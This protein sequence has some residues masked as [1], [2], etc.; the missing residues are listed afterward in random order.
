[1]NHARLWSD[2]EAHSM[3]G[4][5]RLMDPP[6]RF[7]VLDPDARLLWSGIGGSMGAANAL[8]QAL[9][10]ARQRLDFIPLVGPEP[11]PRSLRY[12]DQ[13]VFASRSGRTL[14]TWALISHLRSKP[15][16]GRWKNPPFVLTQDDGNP[17]ARMARAEAWHLLQLPSNVGGRY[18]AF[19]PIG[20]LPLT[21]MGSDIASYLRGARRVVQETQDGHGPW[22]SRVWMAVDQLLEG[23]HRNIKTWVLMPYCNQLR[24]LGAWWVQ[25]VAESL[26]KIAKDGA[27][28]GL[29]PIQAL[30][31]Q[32]QHSQLQRWIAGPRDVGVFLLT[33]GGPPDEGYLAPP[34][35]CPFP[36]LGRW[37]PSQILEAEAEGTQHSLVDAGLPVVWWQLDSTANESNLGCLFMAWQLIV[38]LTG[39]ALGVNPFDQPAVE[40]SKHWTDALLGLGSKSEGE[41]VEVERTVAR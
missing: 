41:L 28:V 35:L 20:T 4:W 25:L 15:D 33:L 32:D 5:L 6:P 12:S 16:W 21:W 29:T 1:M 7:P 9:G 2:L 22:G 17:L 18:S 10:N 37:K 31:P 27:R 36:G 24:G 30:G 14:E 34:R 8:V 39:L 3:S 38:A 11:E 19:T 40:A 23:Y 26:G 13:L